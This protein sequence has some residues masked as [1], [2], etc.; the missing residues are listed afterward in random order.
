MQRITLLI[1]NQIYVITVSVVYVND[2]FA[3][4]L[5]H[6]DSVI[7]LSAKGLLTALGLFSFFIFQHFCIPANAQSDRAQC[8]MGVELFLPFW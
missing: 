6:P 1:F 5:L 2:Q 8:I 3:L 4:L 7:Y